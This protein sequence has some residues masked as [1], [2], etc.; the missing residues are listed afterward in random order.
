MIEFQCE[1]LTAKGVI[2]D[3]KINK[4]QFNV[5]WG[6]TPFRF[7]YCFLC[8]LLHNFFVDEKWYL[9]GANI[10]GEWKGLGKYLIENQNYFP[11]SPKYASA[12]AS[13]MVKLDLI[14]YRELRTR[15]R[16]IQ[17]KKI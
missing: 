15:G 16:P 10:S 11:K 4:G 5:V 3:V 7:P 6:K 14:T 8:D 12:I 1:T 17:L 9:L 2:I 13:I